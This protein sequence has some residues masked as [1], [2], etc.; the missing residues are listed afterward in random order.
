MRTWYI[1]RN[2]FSGSMWIPNA[3]S[4]MFSW[5]GHITCKDAHNTRLVPEFSGPYFLST[6]VELGTLSLARHLLTLASY[7]CCTSG[8]RHFCE[9]CG[10]AHTTL[11]R[12]TLTP[13]SHLTVLK[14]HRPGVSILGCSGTLA[15][16]LMDIGFFLCQVAGFE[17]KWRDT[18][19]L[20][21]RDT[22]VSTGR[23]LKGLGALLEHLSEIICGL[24]SI[25]FFFLKP[26]RRFFLF[27]SCLGLAATQYYRDP[28]TFY[29]ITPQLSNTQLPPLGSEWLLQL[30]PSFLY[31]I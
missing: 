6:Q 7:L 19:G 22:E 12:F 23:A 18:L 11:W 14:V 15:L 17:S 16:F 8:A 1:R 2:N 29:L 24:Y 25:Y 10:L 30:Q 31:Y 3:S 26:D 20:Y 28:G 21:W 5:E 27:Y 9:V 4:L 13:A